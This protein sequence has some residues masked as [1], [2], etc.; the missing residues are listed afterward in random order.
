M[1]FMSHNECYS[2]SNFWEKMSLKG[3]VKTLTQINYDAIE[4]FGEVKIGKVKVLNQGFLYNTENG[5][6]NCYKIFFD[7]AGLIQNETTFNSDGTN[8]SLYKYYYA[9]NKLVR[10]ER[11][12]FENNDITKYTYSQNSMGYI[13]KNII[14]NNTPSTIKY[15]LQFDS[16]NRLAKRIIFTNPFSGE[17]KVYFS[18]LFKYNNFGKLEKCSIFN[19]NNELVENYIFYYNSNH[20][21]SSFELIIEN[22][23]RQKYTYTYKYDHKNNWIERMVYIDNS[24]RYITVLQIN[25][26]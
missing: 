3:R 12:N 24:L 18:H 23:V 10:V 4:S 13:T 9:S 2:Q 16:N 22:N 15:E 21:I 1:L 5:E 6:S 26:F 7:E 8:E 19:Q 25:Y 20:D 11:T 17:W 14:Y